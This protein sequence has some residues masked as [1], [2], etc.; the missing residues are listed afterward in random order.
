MSTTY[1]AQDIPVGSTIRFTDVFG[2]DHD[3]V[4]ERRPVRITSYGGTPKVLVAG[5]ADG[6]VIA[7]AT[8]DVD[9]AVETF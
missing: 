1:A 7:D 5:I 8:F 9:Q 2:R 4:V 3:V 6:Y